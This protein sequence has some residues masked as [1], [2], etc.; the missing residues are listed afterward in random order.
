MQQ[1][2]GWPSWIPGLTSTISK[3]HC[4]LPPGTPKERVDILRKA[5][6]ATLEDPEFLQDAKK[7][8]LDITYVSA[9][10]IEKLVS[11]ILGISQKTKESL[12]FLVRGTKKKT[13]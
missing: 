13:N 5:F 6:K 11:K 2:K 9:E 3:G 10:E 12:G 4:T 7:S 8:K 1:R